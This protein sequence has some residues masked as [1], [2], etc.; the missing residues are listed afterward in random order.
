VPDFGRGKSNDATTSKMSKAHSKVGIQAFNMPSNG[1][2]CWLSEQDECEKAV[3]WAIDEGVRLIDGAAIYFNEEQIGKAVKKKMAAGAVKREE[4]FIITKL[5]VHTMRP[6]QVKEAFEDSRKKLG[7]DYVDLYLM[8]FPLGFPKEEIDAMNAGKPVNWYTDIDLVAVWREMEKLV[9]SGK[10]RAI[11]VCNFNSKQLRQISAAARIP[12]A[13]NQVECNLYFQQKA[14]RDAMKPLGI[15]MM[16]FAP[17]GSP[18]RQSKGMGE[19]PKVL[20]DKTVAAIALRHKKTPAQVLLR[21]LIQ[22][23]IVVIPKSVKKHRIA[24]NS[25]L[26]D[27]SL[28]TEE[29]SKLDRLD[30]GSKGRTMTLQFVS[31]V[32]GAKMEDLPDWPYSSDVY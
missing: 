11:G 21:H 25:S 31:R 26:Y 6:H 16:A 32:G 15:K 12:I 1:L 20:E 8:H 24:E 5:G 28:T 9:D 14:L 27:F 19:D 29:M 2:G 22:S 13:V 7:L 17:L 30:K 3:E 23:G 10:C 4:L 18:G